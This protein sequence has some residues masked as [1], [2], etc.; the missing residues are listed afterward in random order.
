VKKR[1][2]KSLSFPWGSAQI[3]LVCEDDRK[4]KG[5]EGQQFLGGFVVSTELTSLPGLVLKID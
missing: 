5:G 4:I 3:L 2:S 1:G